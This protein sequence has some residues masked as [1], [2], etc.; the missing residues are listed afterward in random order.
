LVFPNINYVLEGYLNLNQARRV[1]STV[2]ITLL[3]DASVLISQFPECP[4]WKHALFSNPLFLEFKELVLSRCAEH[5][6]N[7]ALNISQ[8]VPE[9]ANAIH[10]MNSNVVGSLGA[11]DV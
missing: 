10:G 5:F 7:P 11:I 8:L 3:Q 4:I 2:S 6:Q 9:V 1:C